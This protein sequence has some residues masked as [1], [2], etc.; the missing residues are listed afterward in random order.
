[1]QT[2]RNLEGSDAVNEP[3]HTSVRCKFLKERGTLQLKAQ[4]IAA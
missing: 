1:M 2:A 4:D 3:M